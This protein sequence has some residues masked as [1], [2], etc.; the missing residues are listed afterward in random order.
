MHRT[1]EPHDLDHVDLSHYQVIQVSDGHH[2]VVIWEGPLP[3]GDLRA[4][5]V[6]PSLTDSAST[7]TIS[8]PN[9]LDAGRR[10]DICQHVWSR[11]TGRRAAAQGALPRARQG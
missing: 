6:R 5:E 9:P 4:G 3:L 7:L 1:I 2:S 10:R 8:V 11:V